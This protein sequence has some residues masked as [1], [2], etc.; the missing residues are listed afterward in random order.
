M[1][2]ARKFLKISLS[3]AVPILILAGVFLRGRARPPISNPPLWELPDFSYS[4]TTSAGP[5]TVSKSSLTGRPWLADFIFADCG[6]PCPLMTK[7]MA[8]LQKS[9]PPEVRLVTF[10]VDPD[11]DTLRALQDYAS[12][13][14]ADAKRWFFV[15]P[16]ESDLNKLMREGFRLALNKD[17]AFPLET[18]ITHSTKFVLVD[19][20]GRVRAF[21]DSEGDGWEERVHRE[22]KKL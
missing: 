19:A 14:G 21:L 12:R 7:K 22:L 15:R 16:E 6:G 10:T 20:E 4:A 1:P 5:T 11:R 17:P 3:A 18:R 9:L 8:A 13:Y 2:P